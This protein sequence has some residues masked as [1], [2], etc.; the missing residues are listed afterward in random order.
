LGEGGAIS[1]DAFNNP[2]VVPPARGAQAVVS[3]AQD[4][5]L[6]LKEAKAD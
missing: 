1:L 5:I 4:D 2:A 3:F 6:F